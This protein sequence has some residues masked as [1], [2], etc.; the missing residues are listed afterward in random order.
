MPGRSRTAAAEPKRE[1]KTEKER[2]ERKFFL[3]SRGEAYNGS[4]VY[5][6]QRQ[7]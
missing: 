7:P 2:D 3:R 6:R 5:V 4:Y 1:K